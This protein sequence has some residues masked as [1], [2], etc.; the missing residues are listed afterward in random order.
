MSTIMTCSSLIYHQY[1]D[2][3]HTLMNE[4]K[5]KRERSR[6][7]EIEKMSKA[8]LHRF[9]DFIRNLLIL[10]LNFCIIDIFE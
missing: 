7:G 2:Y 3:Y 8:K 4:R 5:R 9:T 10:T 6:E 1:H